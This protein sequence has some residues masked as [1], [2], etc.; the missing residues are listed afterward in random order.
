MLKALSVFEARLGTC[1]PGIVSAI[2]TIRVIR[3]P[4]RLESIRISSA[5][6]ELLGPDR[7]LIL[8]N[9]FLLFSACLS[10]FSPH[11]AADETQ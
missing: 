7:F 11:P 9:A 5:S 4:V 8:Y 2:S 6:G 10:Q 1:L 3:K